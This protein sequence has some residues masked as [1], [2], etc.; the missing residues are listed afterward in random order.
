[1]VRRSVGDA[2]PPSVMVLFSFETQQ[3]HVEK[4]LPK[5]FQTC[6]GQRAPETSVLVG[7]YVCGL[8]NH[9][10]M[11]LNYPTKD[12]AILRISRL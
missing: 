10:F 4:N 7:V 6:K 9:K 2:T 8:V 1:M 3:A 5:F 11:H 12:R